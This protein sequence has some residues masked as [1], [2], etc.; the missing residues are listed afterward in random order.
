MDSTSFT[1][2][3][4]LKL[5]LELKLKHYKGGQILIEKYSIVCS[6]ACNDSTVVK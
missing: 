2:I 3:E 6:Y 1:V 5:K 4:K